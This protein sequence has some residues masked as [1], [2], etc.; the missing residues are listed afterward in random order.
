[1]RRG[2]KFPITSALVKFQEKKYGSK[3]KE[4]TLYNFQ[5]C[6]EY[7]R[8]NDTSNDLSQQ[9]LLS[10]FSFTPSIVCFVIVYN[11]DN[12]TTIL[13]DHLMIGS[14]GS[15][16]CYECILEKIISKILISPEITHFNISYLF[17]KGTAREKTCNL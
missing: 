2:I 6:Y 5:F 13:Y 15:Y 10:L 14:G 11:V 1:M 7:M 16:K 12:V 3:E 8:V 17:L 4:Q 9:N